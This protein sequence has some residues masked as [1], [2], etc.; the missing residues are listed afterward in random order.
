[1]KHR[2]TAL[3]LLLSLLLLLSAC[4]AGPSRPEDSGA[5]EPPQTEEPAAGETAEET[6]ADGSL[7]SEHLKT[8][9]PIPTA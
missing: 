9:P 4:G 5:R 3:F 2:P 7:L 8:L 1:M 6:L